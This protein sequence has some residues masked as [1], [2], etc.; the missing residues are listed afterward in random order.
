MGGV[1]LIFWFFY[2][3]LAVSRL[4]KNNF[5]KGAFVLD[6]ILEVL[7]SNWRE[8]YW[9]DDKKEFIQ[10]FLTVYS[11]IDEAKMEPVFNCINT[12]MQ[13]SFQAGFQTALKLL[14]LKDES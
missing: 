2:G 5:Q 4:D 3:R 14:L 7:Y 6:S 1:S 13:R 8:K 12:E 11:S 9:C 10:E